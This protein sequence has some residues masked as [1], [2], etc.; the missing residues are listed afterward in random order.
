M[1]SWVRAPSSRPSEYAGYTNFGRKGAL[2]GHLRLYG[3]RPA[4]LALFVAFL[5]FGCKMLPLVFPDLRKCAA[6]PALAR[7]L[8]A[9]P[10][11]RETGGHAVRRAPSRRRRS[12]LML[13]GA[14]RHRVFTQPR[15]ISDIGGTAVSQ[16]TIRAKALSPSSRDRDSENDSYGTSR[17]QIAQITPL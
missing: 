9:L 2:S 7:T 17:P 13:G 10:T 14:L 16:R 1:V 3:W 12:R 15:P 11:A 5:S 8:S 4:G 6:L